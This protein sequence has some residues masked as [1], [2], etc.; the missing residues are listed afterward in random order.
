MSDGGYDIGYRACDCFWGTEPGSLVVKLCE[1]VPTFEGMTVLDAGCGEGK[2]A[3]FLAT[4]GASVDAF[5]ISDV[6]ISHARKLSAACNLHRL[7]FAIGDARDLVLPTNH[8]HLVVAYG[9]FH[10]FRSSLEI[11]N[12]C[13]K[14][15]AAIRA[16]G[17]FIVCAFNDRRQDLLAHPGFAPTALPHEEYGRLF[18]G[19]EILEFTDTDLTETHPHNAIRHTHSMTRLIARKP[20]E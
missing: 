1:I 15:Q 7:R 14:L 16:G 4:K 12:T 3:V 5:D 6:A 8:F 13:G 19:W 17:Y 9:L 20:Q 10:C 11:S 18:N 2:N